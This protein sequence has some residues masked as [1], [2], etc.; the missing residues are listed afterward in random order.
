MA[1]HWMQADEIH[2]FVAELAR[3]EAEETC[4][5]PR[6]V[7][8]PCGVANHDGDASAILEQGSI[9]VQVAE[10]DG[11]G[12]GLVA[13]AGGVR[14]GEVILREK[15]AA[16]VLHKSRRMTHCSVC[17]Q[18]I[19]S[20]S[21]CAVVSGKSPLPLFC[22][23]TCKREY[24]SSRCVEV[25]MPWANVLPDNALLAVRLAIAW[26]KPS[27]SSNTS[28][29]QEQ[30]LHYEA[31]LAPLS[32]S[33]R[34]ETAVLAGI[35]AACW[36]ASARSGEG[37]IKDLVSKAS[38][39][40]RAM[41][42]IETN[43]FA[44]CGTVRWGQAEQWRVGRGVYAI[45]SMLNH[46]CRP[47]VCVS[48]DNRGVL[49]ARAIRDLKE[50]EEATHCYG[51]QQGSAPL[52]QRRQ[53][54]ESCYHFSCTCQACCEEE[55]IMEGGCRMLAFACPLDECRGRGGWI[56]GL[57]DSCTYAHRHGRA[58]CQQCGHIVDTAVLSKAANAVR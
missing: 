6:E 11:C 57:E 7:S 29:G 5:A 4:R 46:S 37:C 36:Q 42:V 9:N 28:T 25:A 51:P 39:V 16:T 41:L 22:S 3:E 40:L 49:V 47:N 35:A 53:E 13:G 27:L 1:L 54:L 34:V 58:A 44:V 10:I 12:R 18:G 48:F 15:A 31:H 32:A 20:L 30:Y 2:R 23:L 17:F 24:L 33:Q 26:T 8:R 38:L 55:N 52:S 14:A 45:A 21:V 19:D 56:C 50:G 43:S